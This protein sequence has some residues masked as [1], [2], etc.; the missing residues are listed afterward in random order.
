MK[1]LPHSKIVELLQPLAD[2]PKVE[3]V[4]LLGSSASSSRKFVS[5]ID[6]D[7]IISDKV[8]W[9]GQI[10]NKEFIWDICVY[11][12]E[13]CLKRLKF[14]P[15]RTSR[16]LLDAIPIVDKIGAYSQLHS[17]AKLI[18]TTYVTSAFVKHRLLFELQYRKKKIETSLENQDLDSVGYHSVR[19]ILPISQAYLAAHDMPIPIPP[20]DKSLLQEVQLEEITQLQYKQLLHSY[21]T[22]RG[23]VAINLLNQ[24][25]VWLGGA[26]QDTTVA[27]RLNDVI[28]IVKLLRNLE[29]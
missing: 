3:A 21:G 8:L 12:V 17:A 15:Y 5:D 22:K 19:A 9:E 27:G 10:T 6:L 1:L 7:I 29:Q 28:D 14:D 11:S 16:Y 20:G 23:E 13:D 18:K 4:I 2:H 26:I 25:M 24:A